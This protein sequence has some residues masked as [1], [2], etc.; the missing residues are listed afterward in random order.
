MD[1]EA[2]DASRQ[3]MTMPNEKEEFW[4][5][6]DM[7]RKRTGRLHQRGKKLGDGEYHLTVHA[8]IFN[9]EGKMLIQKRQPFKHGWSGLWDITVGGSALAGEDSQTAMM[10]ELQ[11]E[12]GLSVDLRCV[13]PHLSVQFDCG[14]DDVFLIKRDVDP[15]MLTLQYEEV[16][17]VRY[18]DLDEILA[19]MD[20]GTFIAYQKHLIALF[21]DM[22][23]KYGALLD[24]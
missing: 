6:Y 11:E 12:I 7:H 18:A 14:F 4:D 23:D 17:A 9:T 13:R 15:S 22:K 19:M 24:V 20:E 1:A 2:G 8:C 21:F 3:K 16:E 5:I 10:R